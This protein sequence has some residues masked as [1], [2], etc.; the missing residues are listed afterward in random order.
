MAVSGNRRATPTATHWGNYDV[1]TLDGRVVA[2]RPAAEDPDPSP[3]GPGMPMAMQ[4]AVRLRAPMVRKSWLE[5][6]PAPA[7]GLRGRDAFVEVGWEEAIDL[8]EWR[9]RE[10]EAQHGNEAIFGGSY[11]WGSAGRFH[12]AQSQLHR[13]LA[14][15]GG[16]TRSVNSYS[17]AALEVLL[18]H[19]IG[20]H[21]TS[22]FERMPLWEEVAEHGELVIAF[23]GLALKNSQVNHGGVGRHESSARTAGSGG[24]WRQVHQHQSVARR[25]RRFPAGAVDRARGRTRTSRSCWA[26]PTRLLEDGSQ[27][28]EFLD[29]CCVGWDRFRRLPHRRGRRHRARCRVGGRHHRRW[30]PPPSMS[31]LVS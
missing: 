25:R 30:T 21:S 4:D 13:F 24:G 18:P 6:G 22:I 17:F 1:E 23:G 12:H 11:G 29:R 26:W 31:W 7:G 16:Y 9:A 8:V 10:G 19:V 14:M 27:D 28:E 2:L 5:H 20:G 15:H 3:I